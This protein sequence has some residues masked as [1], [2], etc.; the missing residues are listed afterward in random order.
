MKQLALDI[1]LADSAR[2]D[3]YYAGPN[4]A[5][6]SA[7][8]AAALE[9]GW[10][11]HWIWGATGTG[12][13]HLLQSAVA[14]AGDAGFACAWLPLDM[15]GLVPSMLEGMGG[16]D[17]LCVDNVDQVAGD[18]EWERALFVVFEELRA[19]SGRLLVTAAMP[20][21]QA[22][23]QLR[24]LSSRLASGPTW[25]LQALD[26]AGLLEALQLRARWRGFELPDDAGRYLLRRSERSSKALFD[27][28]D[29]LDSAALAAQRRLTVP[30]VKS[31][32]ESV[33]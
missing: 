18:A 21:P 19:S 30:F 33:A 23:F 22:G 12:R 20:M 28:L 24:D 2:F 16:L 11:V 13:S 6:I 25:K 8:R 5:V 17:L 32:L 14:A 31:Y 9:P 26:D 4:G 3:S 1:K 29:Q 7:L 10:Q 27:L 15:P